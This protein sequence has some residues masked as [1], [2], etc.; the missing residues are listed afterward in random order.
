ME[1]GLRRGA[2][3]EVGDGHRVLATAPRH[4]GVTD[5]VGDLAGERDRDRAEA[6][7]VDVPVVG[8]DAHPEL[9][10]DLERQATGEADGVLPVRVEDEV[11]RLHGEGRADLG[12]FVS[13][14]HRVNDKAA[15]TLGR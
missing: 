4:V 9:E 15:L 7:T 14:E 3:A 2:V 12:G 8:G 6:L 11:V 10:L 5:C 1:V 13:F